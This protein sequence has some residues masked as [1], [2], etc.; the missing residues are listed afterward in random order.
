MKKRFWALFLAVMMV[1]SILPTTAFAED[2]ESAGD[3]LSPK[4]LY[5]SFE[6]KAVG[7]QDAKITLSKTAEYKG[8]GAYKVTLSAT[9]EEVIKP[10]PTEVVFVLDASGS[11]R[12]CTLKHKYEGGTCSDNCP[13]TNGDF[14]DTDARWHIATNAIASMS[15]ALKGQGASVKYVAF[16]NND[17]AK[18]VNSYSVD[19]LNNKGFQLAKNTQTYL[20][21]GVRAGIGCFTSDADTNKVLIIVADGDSS[22]GYSD[23]KLTN[24]KK[25]ANNTVYTVGFTFSSDNF[26]EMAT[27]DEHYYNATDAESLDVVLGDIAE[28]IVGLINDPMGSKV[29]L[30]KDSV[31]ISE[32][33]LPEATIDG[34]TINWTDSKGLKGAVTL[35]YEVTI[36]PSEQNPGTLNIPLNGDAKLNY[37][38]NNNNYSVEFPVPTAVIKAATLDVDYMLDGDK[39]DN[40]HEWINLTEGEPFETGANDIPKVDDTVTIKKNTY[41][42]T[43]V[44]GEV[45]TDPNA[46]AYKVIVTLSENEPV[47]KHN[48]VYKIV[49]DYFADENYKTIKSVS[50]GEALSLIADN[51]E[52]VGYT[53]SGWSGLPATMP[54]ED[55]T[56]TGSYQINQ[57]AYTVNY[58]KDEIA[59][60]NLLQTDTGTANFNAAIPY[61]NGAYR[62]EG[63][64]TPGVVSGQTTVTAVAADNV[65]NIVY[66]KGTYQYTVEYYFDEVIDETLTET[67]AAVYGSEISAYTDK[68]KPGYAFDYATAPITIGTGENVIKVYYATDEWKGGDGIPDKYQ[69]LVTYKVQG[70]TWEGTDKADKQEVFTLYAKNDDGVWTAV[71][72]APVLGETIPTGMQ[73]DAG[74]LSFGAWSAPV[75]YK[76]TAAVNGDVFVYSFLAEQEITFHF[77]A[78]GGKWDAAVTGY[79]M[80]DD[81]TIASVKIAQGSSVSEISPA[82][83][84]PECSVDGHE[85]VFAG[86]YAVADPDAEEYKQNPWDFSNEIYEDNYTI[87]AH[88][89]LNELPVV[90]TFE[91]TLIIN[92]QD[93]NGASLKYEET[94]LIDAS[95]SYTPAETITIGED[96]YVYEGITVYSPA[97]ALNGTAKNGEIVLLLL[98]YTMDNL[99]D[100]EDKPTGGD[101]IPDKYQ[102]LVT[103]K[104]LNGTWSDD[105]SADII[106][107]FTLKTL[108]AETGEWIDVEVSLGEMPAGMKPAAGYQANS[109]RWNEA[110]S[111]STAVVGNATYIYRFFTKNAPDLS[112]TKIANKSSVEVGDKVTYTITVTNTGNVDLTNVVVTDTFEKGGDQTRT[113]TIEKL[114][115]GE[116][117]AFTFEYKTVNADRNGLKNVATAVSN[118]TAPKTADAVEVDVER[119]YDPVRPVG[120]SKPKLNKEDHYAYIVGYPDGLVHPERNITRAEVSTIFFRMLLDESREDFWA[121]ENWFSDVPADKWFNN[122]VSTL[123]NAGLITGYPDGSFKPNANITRAEFATIAI[124]FFLEE[125][126]EITENNLTDVKGHWA[127]ANINLAYA[128]GLINGYP[129][130]T[131]RPNQLI[132]RAEAMTIVNRVLERAPHKDHLLD[133]MIEWPDNRNEDVWYYADVQEAT[134]SHQFYRDS[135]DEHEVWTELL[136]VRDWAALEREWS[137]ANSSRNPGEVVDINISTP[138][139]EKNTLVL[140]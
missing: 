129:D 59:A 96:K 140:N 58:Y 38:Y 2:G 37:T 39:I 18:Q 106:K 126:V 29:N 45:P 137:Q 105:T 73:P 136:P 112:I 77:D 68:N 35:T 131:F 51:M 16:N 102:A 134:N 70:G 71:N 32:K 110:I 139:A 130:G 104:V 82:P 24:F 116:S 98:D 48:I 63:Y 47:T 86:W 8:D 1:V 91:A 54:N 78:N 122:A 3:K 80:N 138:E 11:M 128:L 81:L 14:H 44:S 97:Q 34:S 119:D 88:W 55:V 67:N 107:V 133:D 15:T 84:A 109:G 101:N 95:W 90:P 100:K 92:C 9:A 33:G 41:W 46:A 103:Y 61:T 13:Y 99:N 23:E 6:G 125:G 74:Y 113:W 19:D 111:A 135:K 28:K 20:M 89:D 53:W 75:P 60:D 79:T 12:W 132:T 117:K 120:P 72:P 127:E 40:D 50:S 36:K 17:A 10:K 49:G 108:S 85:Y 27:S 25:G 87:Y 30:D 76:N 64:A 124:R 52:M 56:V 115:V 118:E 26:K 5:Y 66:S 7:E 42:V 121:Q 93:E 83:T 69:A 43:A 31:E 114:A 4:P 62:P 21:D 57:Y 22:D 94:E 65:L 123:A